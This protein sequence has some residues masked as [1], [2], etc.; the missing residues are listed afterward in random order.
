MHHENIGA[1]V[2]VARRARGVEE[3]RVGTLAILCFDDVVHDS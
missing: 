2:G 3:S 1:G